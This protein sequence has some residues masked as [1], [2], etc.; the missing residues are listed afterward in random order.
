MTLGEKKTEF[1]L[2]SEEG[3]SIAEIS[4]KTGIASNVLSQWENELARKKKSEPHDHLITKIYAIEE[5]SPMKDIIMVMIY[6]VPGLVF[7]VSLLR[8]FM[9]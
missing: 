9:N 4:L 7:V 8:F 1:R 6:A 2:L 3:M 5:I